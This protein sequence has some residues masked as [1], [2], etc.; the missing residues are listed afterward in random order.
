[1]YQLLK[2]S[3]QLIFAHKIRAKFKYSV[4]MEF[5]KIQRMKLL[6]EKS[7]QHKKNASK[8]TFKKEK[9]YLIAKK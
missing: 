7:V 4:K 6:L 1:V 8:L 2:P 3:K 5:V 9:I